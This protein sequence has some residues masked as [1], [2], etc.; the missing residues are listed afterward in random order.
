MLKGFHFLFF[1]FSFLCSFS[2]N[3]VSNGSF[4]DKRGGRYTTRPWRFTNTVDQFSRDGKSLRPKGTEGWDIPLAR[5]GNVHVGIRVHPKYR[6]FLQIKLNQKLD[7]GHYYLFEMYVRSSV[8]TQM[9]LESI[10][11]SLYPRKPAYT[12]MINLYQQPPQI[13]YRD[14]AGIM[15][16]DSIPWIKVRGLYRAKGGEKYLSIGN[17]E[18]TKFKEKL[19]FIDFFSPFSF[20]YFAYYYIDDIS[21]VETDNQGIPLYLKDKMKEIEPKQVDSLE[22][23]IDT[24][25]YSTPDSLDF[26]I[27]EE[28]YIYNIEKTDKLVLNKIRFE[29]GSST[30]LPYSYDELELV[31]EYLNA[32]TYAK[33]KIVGHTDNVG[34]SAANQKL[35]EKRAKSVY[36]YFIENR[37]SKNRLSYS[38]KG[39]SEPIATN[40]TS[41][42]KN[43]NRRVE[44]ILIK[45]LPSQ[46]K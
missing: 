15:Q 46:A 35:S 31:L 36:D 44:I 34:S 1:L 19:K 20:K 29:F 14:K 8:N 41:T 17:F 43:Q 30:L 42:G 21:L 23:A 11:A 40:S 38:G 2:Q 24:S 27:T 33:I 16:S 7:E 3:L 12:T 5:T 32:N 28:N 22:L 39:E 37:I 26:D 45:D 10:G 18:T 25:F 13:V 9:L 6:E 4:E